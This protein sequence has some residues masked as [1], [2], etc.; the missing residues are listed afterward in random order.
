MQG[1][2]CA[3]PRFMLFLLLV[4]LCSIALCSC[5]TT[6]S[7]AATARPGTCDV[8]RTNVYL[9]PCQSMCVHKYVLCLLACIALLCVCMIYIRNMAPRAWV[10]DEV[11]LLLYG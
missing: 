3:M 5:S 10:S 4:V 8:L 9:R 2:G 1:A 11:R 7:K 6:C